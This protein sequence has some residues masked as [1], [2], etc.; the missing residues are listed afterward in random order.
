MMTGFVAG[1]GQDGV[2]EHA[3]LAA[4]PAFEVHHDCLRGRIGQHEREELGRAQVYGVADADCLAEADPCP[5]RMMGR[6]QQDVPALGEQR[7]GTCGDLHARHVHA[8]RRGVDPGTVGADHTGPNRREPRPEALLDFAT[9]RGL[10]AEAAGDHDD[11]GYVVRRAGVHDLLDAV[12]SDRHHGEV[13]PPGHVSDRA[14]RGDPR[15]FA[16]R[17]VDRVEWP[18]EACPDQRQPAPPADLHGICRGAHERNAARMQ[19][20]GYAIG[21]ARRGEAEVHVVWTSDRVRP[22]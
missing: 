8:C 7:D 6:V 4:L 3:C 15:D 14:K 21:R 9:I 10:L 2:A 11:A 19:H 13:D 5:P 17:R 12:G 16:G 1:V 20:A 18:L 22:G